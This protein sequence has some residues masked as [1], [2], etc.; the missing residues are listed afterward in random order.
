MN[1]S[2]KRIA[3]IDISFLFLLMLSGFFDGWIQELIYYCAFIVPL[4]L[5]LFLMRGDCSKAMLSSL[6]LS[7]EGLSLTLPLVVPATASILAIAYLSSLIIPQSE[8]VTSPD[9][10]GHIFVVILTYALIPALLE[11]LLFRYVPLVLFS[12][13]ERRSVIL[14][15]SAAFAVLHCD[16][17][18]LPY[19]FFA[20]IVFMVID[21]ALG[22]VWPSVIIHA[23]NNIASILLMRY[24]GVSNFTIV[25]LVVIALAVFISCA[26]SLFMRRRYIALGGT[27][28]AKMRTAGKVAQSIEMFLVI[29]C[30]LLITILN[31]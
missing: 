31:Y 18:K 24:G 28:S 17:T 20:G 5:V 7:R 6:K 30:A 27:L 1:I 21:F 8:N 22:S 9:V 26:A 16:L 25:F 19:A 13:F 4:S 11:E 29:G 10:Y 3:Y 15:T 23:V 14:L 2:L 12:G